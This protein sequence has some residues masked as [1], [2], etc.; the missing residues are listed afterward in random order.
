[1]SKVGNAQ[2]SNFY[3]NND[4]ICVRYTYLLCCLFIYSMYLSC[5]ARDRT[6]SVKYAMNSISFMRKHNFINFYYF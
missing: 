3:I 6:N 2:I 5:Y 4:Y 1:M